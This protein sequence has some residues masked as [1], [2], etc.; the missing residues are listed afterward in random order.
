MTSIRIFGFIKGVTRSVRGNGGL[1]ATMSI[2]IER[3]LLGY[4]LI[5]GADLFPHQH[6]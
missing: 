5:S 4:F 6:C 3:L 2:H 1:Y